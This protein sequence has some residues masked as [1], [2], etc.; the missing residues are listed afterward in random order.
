MTL[1]YENGNIDHIHLQQ[2]LLIFLPRN[3]QDILL[4]SLSIKDANNLFNNI[5][6][7]WIPPFDVQW[8]S[9]NEIGAGLQLRV[10]LE[11]LEIKKRPQSQ[12]GV[13]YE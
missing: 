9:K 6:G 10:L 4:L 2:W 7:W 1:K 12:S 13:L 8:C 11:W 3:V 5:T